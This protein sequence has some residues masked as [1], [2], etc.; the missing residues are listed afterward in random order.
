MSILYEEQQGI[1]AKKTG[2]KLLFSTVTVICCRQI[3]SIKRTK[4]ISLL[5]ELKRMLPPP[6]SFW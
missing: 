4:M 2:V 1:H 5:T 3:T 6:P